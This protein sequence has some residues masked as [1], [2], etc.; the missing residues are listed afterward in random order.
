MEEARR[1]LRRLERIELLDRGDVPAETVLNEVRFLLA[2]AEAWVAVE[3]GGT[4]RAE[5][6]LDRC[7]EALEGP[8]ATAA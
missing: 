7:R 2:E 1:V 6:A 5:E 8:F 3:P 4:R